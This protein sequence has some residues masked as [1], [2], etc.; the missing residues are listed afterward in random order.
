MT[1]DQYARGKLEQHFL[2]YEALHNCV[3]CLKRCFG[4][5]LCPLL[6]QTFGHVLQ[7]SESLITELRVFRH[8]LIE[9]TLVQLILRHEV[10]RSMHPGQFLKQP[11]VLRQLQQRPQFSGE[12][13][14]MN[15]P[16]A[17]ERF[18]HTF[19]IERFKL[20][21]M[22]PL[23]TAQQRVVLKVEIAAGSD[24]SCAANPFQAVHQPQKNLQG[25]VPAAKRQHI[26]GVDHHHHLTKIR[27]PCA[28]ADDFVRQPS[29]HQVCFSFRVSKLIPLNEKE[30][31]GGPLFNMV[32]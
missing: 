20:Y 1:E 7:R 10:W 9:K 28:L 27:Q 21:R 16:I 23:P 4:I 24:N 14:G 8:Y 25:T 12:A 11:K 32:D 31:P 15:S 3:V 18:Y 29:L 5:S 13:R 30:T 26:E 19:K 17:Q 22:L 6:H 2:A